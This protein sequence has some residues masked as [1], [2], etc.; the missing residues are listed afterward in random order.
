[1]NTPPPAL[2]IPRITLGILWLVAM[3]AATVWVMMPFFL[4][5]FWASTLVIATWPILLAVQRRL[6][7]RRGPA[8]AVM[9]A[10]MVALLVIP[11]WLGISAISDNADRVQKVMHSLATE[12]LPPPPGWLNRVPLV[13]DRLVEKWQE[14]SGHPEELLAWIQPHAQ[15]AVRW[16]VSKAKGLVQLLLLVV[17]SGIL[18]ASGEK[19][20][21]GVLRFLRRLAGDR[22][23]AVGRLAAKAVRA[24]ALGV[25]VT[26]LAQTLI[27]GLGLV[28]GGVPHAGVL[29]AIIFVLS[30]AQLGPLLVVLPAT[31][32][33]YSSGEVVRGTLL[34]VFSVLALVLDNVL[35]PI[36]IKRGADLS[37]LL[38]LT[39]VI[40]GVLAFGVV[41][42]FIGPVLLAVAWT[43]V[44]AWVGDIDR[45][46]EASKPVEGR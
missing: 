23:E 3:V 25:V 18:F 7:G 46:P 14:F 2:D 6:G 37:L 17:I 34:L 31:I 1:M 22:G 26:A 21:S 41:G 42:L 35:R 9:I 13:G 16:L 39:G 32:W 5:L 28:V 44:V 33:V 27:S 40:G 29:T 45:S 36:L 19:V 11:T 24:V 38:I 4:A 15:D 43:L 20:A 30:I 8:V 12:G 10:A